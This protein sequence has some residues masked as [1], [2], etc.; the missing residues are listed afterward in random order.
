[1]AA[2]H[3]TV[4]WKNTTLADIVLTLHRLLP[5]DFSKFT[6]AT[7][8]VIAILGPITAIVN[9]IVIAAIWKD[10]FKQ[11]RS[12]PSNIIIGSMATCDFLGGIVGGVMMS[13]FYFNLSSKNQLSLDL[14]PFSFAILEFLL[15]LSVFHDLALMIDRVIAVVNP[16]LYKLRVRR[17]RVLISVILIWVFHLVIILSQ[18][19]LVKHFHVQN[20]MFFV[21]LFL[22]VGIASF[23]SLFIVYNVRK[24]T[25]KMRSET[26]VDQNYKIIVARQRKLT[27]S[28]SIICLVVR[29]CFAPFF[30]T[31]FI[32]LTCS[33][34]HTSLSGIIASFFLSLIMM[35][36]KFFIS[37]FLYAF[38]L[39]KFKRPVA[40]IVK[41][42]LVCCP[43]VH[44]NEL[45]NSQTAS[46]NNERQEKHKNPRQDTECITTKL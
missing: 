29:V 39:P 7:G 23:L 24:Q 20:V 44:T 35:Y 38:R 30:I 41:S 16:L 42:A 4:D 36:L 28:I 17:K 25:K 33:S 34:C 3:G 2:I 26:V 14:A 40:L 13:L 21:L 27:K 1:M 15:K 5:E 6:I 12:T 32:L 11:L 9:G 37:P 45:Q 18:V 46:L 10:P 31:W 43:S 8:T 22:A 19:P